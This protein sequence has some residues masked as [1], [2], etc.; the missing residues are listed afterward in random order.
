MA[1]A[2]AMAVSIADAAPSLF[3][4]SSWLIHR[5]LSQKVESRDLIRNRTF[6]TYVLKTNTQLTSPRKRLHFF[7][8]GRLHNK[9]FVD[10]TDAGIRKICKVGSNHSIL[11]KVEVVRLSER[12]NALPLK[13]N[14]GTNVEDDLPRPGSV[15]F[16]RNV[17]ETRIE[18]HTTLESL[19]L[20]KVSSDQSRAMA[21]SE[22]FAT[23]IAESGTPVGIVV[24][25]M[26]EGRD[27]RLRGCVKT[28]LALC[29][30]RCL[31]SMAEP[32]FGDFDLLLTEKPV[33]QPTEPTI[34]V[35]LGADKERSPDEVGDV[36]ELD[37]DLDDK[38]HFPRHAKEVDIST[39][40]RDTI[41][42]EIPFMSLCHA[43]CKGLC[44]DCGV[45]LN[46][47]VCKCPTRTAKPAFGVLEQLKKQ[48]KEQQ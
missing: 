4:S 39:Y 18:F 16:R 24:D 42:L 20:A 47:T 27:F 9:T 44:L 12:A 11:E 32:I 25:V 37:L 35:V 23:G 7:A 34:G 3:P 2:M 29:C 1:M 43:F 15:V 48:M 14:S 38:L 8:R 30:N 19:G 36:G 26:K 28:V 45:N 41:H 6:W 31:S 21:V 22:G 46:I 10:I 33:K 13:K 40:I 17:S 5:K